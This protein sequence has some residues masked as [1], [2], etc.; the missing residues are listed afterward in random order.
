M[1]LQSAQAFLAG[2]L[3][4]SPVGPNGSGARGSGL[5]TGKTLQRG[6]VPES[7]V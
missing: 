3:N 7:L 5:V 1:G 6:Q 4:S 2:S